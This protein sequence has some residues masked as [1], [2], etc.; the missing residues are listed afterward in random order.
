MPLMDCWGVCCS[1]GYEGDRI[2]EIVYGFLVG[3]F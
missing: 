3:I 2:I 1:L